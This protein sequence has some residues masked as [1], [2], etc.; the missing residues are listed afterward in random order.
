MLHLLPQ[1]FILDGQTGIHDPRGMIGRQLQVRVH[2]VTGSASETQNIV[3]LVNQAGIYVDDI[4]FE[5]LACSDAVLIDEERELGVCVCAKTE[6]RNSQ[7][8]CLVVNSTPQTPDIEVFS[9]GDRLSQQVSREAVLKLRIPDSIYT[10]RDNLGQAGVLEV[11]SSGVVLTGGGARLPGLKEITE[12]ILRCPTRTGQPLIP[13]SKL[14][15][16]LDGP[17][18]AAA[19]GMVCYAHRVRVLKSR[20]SGSTGV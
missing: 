11:L 18:F 4:V 5:A 16:F 10:L 1:E 3:T 20:T 13:I 2:V 14:P 6:A 12:E 7:F 9:V 15:A 8:G 17:E 19:I